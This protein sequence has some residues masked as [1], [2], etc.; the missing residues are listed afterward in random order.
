MNDEFNS[1]PL[2]EVAEPVG[3]YSVTC[4]E[5]ESFGGRLPPEKAAAK[6]KKLRKKKKT[7]SL[8]V[9]LV[10]SAVA[11]TAVIAGPLPFFDEEISELWSE[12]EYGEHE[13]HHHDSEEGE[14][15]DYWFPSLSNLEPNGYAE[16][17][18]VMNEDYIILYD[19]EESTSIHLNEA[20]AD[21]NYNPDG[22]EGCRYDPENNTL[23]LED[24]TGTNLEANLMGNGFTISLSGENRLDSLKVWGWYYG[25]SVLITGDGTLYVNKDKSREVGITL[26]AEDS[27]SCL[28]IDSGVK[29]EVWGSEAAIKVIASKM[30]DRQIFYMDPLELNSGKRKL[31][32]GGDDDFYTVVTPLG[33]PSTHVK[34]S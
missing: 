3:E 15:A 2:S 19:D 8:K 25:G 12:I 28:M 34:F 1:R 5:D 4:Q 7:K 31:Y 23:Y 30:D 21:E 6:A 10:T 20:W 32:T 33:K 14:Y 26:M 29:V 27:E 22:I 13:H 11:G 24:F 18:G 9:L 16:G 17:W